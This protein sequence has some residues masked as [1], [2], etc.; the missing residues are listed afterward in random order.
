MSTAAMVE[1]MSGKAPV[2]TSGDVAPSVMMEFKNACH[3]FFEAK[4][5]P[6][7][8]QAVLYPPPHV[9]ISTDQRQNC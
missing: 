5:V 2:L 8:K 1:P 7:D 3:D 9:L 6:Q 4:S